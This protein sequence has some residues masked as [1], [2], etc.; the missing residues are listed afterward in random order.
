MVSLRSAIT[1]SL[2]SAITS[3]SFPMTTKFRPMGKQKLDFA[4]P[5]DEIY[6]FRPTGRRKLFHLMIG[7]KYRIFIQWVDENYFV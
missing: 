5:L 6:K 7:R 3:G 4:Y 2:R 1:I